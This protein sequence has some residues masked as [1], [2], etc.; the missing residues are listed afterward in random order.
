MPTEKL[1]ICE[2]YKYIT[3]RIHVAICF[4][5]RDVNT[6]ND[7]LIYKFEN[8][9]WNNNYP[10]N[11]W[12]LLLAPTFTHNF[13]LKADLK[14]YVLLSNGNELRYFRT[15]GSDLA[16]QIVKSSYYYLNIHKY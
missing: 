3:L 15:I 11:V 6:L 5:V 12:G 2:I 14:K 4:R 9:T 10:W 13:S 7:Y 16:I 8:W 1:T